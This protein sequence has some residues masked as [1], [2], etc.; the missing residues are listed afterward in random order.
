MNRRT[1]LI[2]TG[3]DRDPRTGSS[4]FPIYQTSTFHQ[5]DPEHLGAYD[6]ARSDNPTREALENAIAKL[7]GGAQGLAFASGMAATCSSLLLFEPGD[8]VL[9]SRDIYGG[10]YRALTTLF[11]RWKL[12]AVTVDAGDP[13]AVRAAIGPATRGLFVETP[14]NP[15]L[16]ITD[17]RAMA[18]IAKEHGLL[19]IVD[20]TFM[21][22]H[23]QRPLELGFDL[24]VHSATKFIGGHS[25]LVAGLAVARETELGRRLRMIQNTVGAILGPQDSWLA[26][27]GLRTLAVRIEAQQATA[28]R[29]AE[30]LAARPEVK[31]VYYPGLPDHPGRAVH[32]G[33]ADGPGAV[34][35]FELADGPAAI[36]F[37]KRARLPLVGVSLGGIETIL[38]YPATMS[39]AAI[40]RAERHARGI[41]DGLVRISAGLESFEDLAADLAAALSGA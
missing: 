41:Q 13:D 26:L 4:S 15:L 5:S 32:E 31:R 1:R 38:S 23:L 37:L 3:G 6:Y 7:E 12:E 9:V 35:S 19:S 17:L 8:Q 10:T 14:A 27:R 21:T 25:D 2:H 28:G 29:L 36:A 33:Q 18:A 20:N 22:P 11:H 40:P 34:L 30:W 16:S 39:H 24:V